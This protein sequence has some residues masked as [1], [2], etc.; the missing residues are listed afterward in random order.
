ML[1]NI[2]P[3]DSMV[4]RRSDPGIQLRSTCILVPLESWDGDWTFIR[5]MQTGDIADCARW[6]AE[7][8]LWQRYGVTE[9]S[10]A[11]RFRAAL[12]AGATIYVA[13]QA[14]EVVGFV[15]F[16]ERGAF[17]HS[18]YIRLIGVRPGARGH[19]IG[20]ALLEFV[21]EKSFAAGRDI[22]LLVSDFNTDAQRWYIR[23]GYRQVGQI[24]SYVRQDVNE[25]IFRKTRQ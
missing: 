7:T 22:F 4:K 24:D 20:R 23:Q 18:G 6:I 8:P 16:V 2:T 21:E 11:D 1:G 15:W 14:G 12:D 10:M 17:D 9:E 19:G 13:E 5:L 3:G 25:L